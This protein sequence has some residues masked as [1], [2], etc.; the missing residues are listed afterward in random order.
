MLWIA[1][2]E[3]GSHGAEDRRRNSA[4]SETPKHFPVPTLDAS[5]LAVYKKDINDGSTWG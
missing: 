2:E 5:S 1:R 3:Q 4:S